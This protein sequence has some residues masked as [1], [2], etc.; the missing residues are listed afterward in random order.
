MEPQRRWWR[1][2]PDGKRISALGFGCSSLWAR[3]SF[4]EA[5]AAAI[6]DTLWAGEV[7]H[8]DTGPS[9]GA[10]LGER[11]LGAWLRDKPLSEIAVATKVGTNL[12]DGAI[13]RSF[14][15]DA[16]E[17][18][19]HDSLARLGIER[20]DVL[21]LHG[22]TVEDLTPAVFALFDRLKRDGRIGLSGV[23]SFDSR[24]LEA[25][26]ATP[27]DVAMLQYNA[28]DFRNERAMEKLAA[29]GK[30]VM[31]GTALARARFDP[32]RFITRTRAQAWYLARM[33]RHDPLFAFKG[34]RLRRRLAATGKPP[35]EAAL[36]FAAGHPLILSNLFGTASVEHAR[37]NARAG[38]GFLDNEQWTRLAR[39]A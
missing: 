11:R 13:V 26:A 28:G 18:S 21:Y 22:P 2:L 29:A 31:S 38:H 16:M 32:S 33:L 5:D 20:V 39:C 25:A 35:A 4:A 12:I 27:L 34:L 10:G 15:P 30:A 24:V 14:E 1:S 9:Y 23:N 6:L 3:P 8:F 19:F 36:Q 17:T 37:A 7:N